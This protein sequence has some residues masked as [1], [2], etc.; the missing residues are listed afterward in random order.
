[1]VIFTAGKYKEKIQFR[2]TV[3]FLR[4]TDQFPGIS[5]FFGG[6]GGGVGKIIKN[7]DRILG[8]YFSCYPSCFVIFNAGVLKK[9]CVLLGTENKSF[10]K[11]SN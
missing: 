2:A 10:A 7:A 8:F 6:G 4:R 9:Y 1:M 5:Y 11:E 3:I